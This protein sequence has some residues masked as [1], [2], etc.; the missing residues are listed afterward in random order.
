[1]DV[2]DVVDRPA[3]GVEQRG[4][5]ADIILFV[6]QGRDLVER[7]AVVDNVHRGVEEKRGD[8]G[9]A[10]FFFLLLDHG[11]EPADGVGFESTHGSASV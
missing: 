10:L 5:A 4:A 3:D 1:M 8:I 2:P 6:R 7:H 9:F 11:V